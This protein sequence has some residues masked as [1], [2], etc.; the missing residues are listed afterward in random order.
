M[1]AICLVIDRLHAGFLGCYGNTWIVSPEF[2]RLAAESFVFD[3]ALIDAPELDS[4]YRSWW[5]GRHAL[6][7][8]ENSSCASLPERLRQAGVTTTLLTDDPAVD[9]ALP[10]GVASSIERRTIAPTLP[11]QP[12]IDSRQAHL[13]HL[14]DEALTWLETAREPFL[15]WMHSGSLGQIW[16]APQEL[17]SQYVAE[18]EPTS[19][20]GIV[21]PRIVLPPNFDPDQLLAMAQAYAG[22]IT[23]LDEHV[24]HFLE[25][26]RDSSLASNTLLVVMSARGMP[27]GEHRRVGAWD[28]A[29]HGELVHIPWLMR[30]PDGLGALN[31]S[32]TLA[33]PADLPLTLLDWWGLEGQ[34]MST[35]ARSLLPV[36]RGDQLSLRD[37]VCIQNRHG[38]RGVRTAKWFLRQSGKQD[39]PGDPLREMTH[40]DEAGLRRWLYAKPDD[41][42]EV[43]ELSARCQEIGD[44]LA[45]AYDDFLNGCR[46]GNLA[47]LPSLDPVVQAWH[48]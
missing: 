16:D 47:N 4:L 18:D 24:G 3:H 13:H 48:A 25:C 21:P 8:S 45:Q 29:L 15:L 7:P 6:E 23:L 40:S 30:F 12:A 35:A 1:N 14:F 41:R 33:Q 26:L 38:E 42:F 5:L 46:T 34:G 11:Q 9:A 32:Q 27:L 17:R 10:A 37:R 31:R 44:S 2:N 39:A 43:N 20:L 22:Q 19:P 36:V 28:E